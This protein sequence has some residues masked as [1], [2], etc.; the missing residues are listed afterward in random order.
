[1]REE[2]LDAARVAALFGVARSAWFASLANAGLLLF[3]LWDSMPAPLLVAWFGTLLALLLVRL[4]LQRAYAMEGAGR[5][6]RRWETRFALGAFA[7][8]ALWA[9]PPAL[10]FPTS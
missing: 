8:G 5:S 10:F 2:R 9:V 6:P 7:A 1:M 3:V 4:G